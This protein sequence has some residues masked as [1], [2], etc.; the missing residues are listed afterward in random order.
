MWKALRLL[1]WGE[2]NPVEGWQPSLSS[3]GIPRLLNGYSHQD[4]SGDNM[5]AVSD[6]V[7]VTFT[8]IDNKRFQANYSIREGAYPKVDSTTSARPGAVKP[9]GL[10]S[11][12]KFWLL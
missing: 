7:E 3:I 8:H 4:V 6:S 12:L 11:H 1:G 5:V 10:W 9:A 2:R